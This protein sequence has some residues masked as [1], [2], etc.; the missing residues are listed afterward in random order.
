MIVLW[1]RMSGL[2]F[3][4]LCMA[5]VATST[6]ANAAENFLPEHSK[7]TATETR[8]P[9]RDGK[10]LAADV[11]L[12][13]SAKDPVATVLIQTPYDKNQS[14]G[15]FKVA[16]GQRGF[17][18]YTIK[19]CAIVITDWRGRAGSTDALIPESIPGGDEDGFDTIEWIISQPWCNGKIGSWGP[20]ALARVQFMTARAH[21]PNHVCA[22]PFVMPLNLDYD[23]YFPGGVLWEEFIRVLAS[24]GFDRRAWLLERPI[25]NELWREFER[26][27]FV[28]PSD[29]QIPM[30]VQGG[31]YDTY[32]DGVIRA[33]QDIKTGGGE[34][35][36]AHSRLLM[37]PWTH[38]SESA[39]QGELTFESAAYHGAEQAVEFLEHWLLGE[40]N[41]EGDKPPVTYYQMGANEWRTSQSWPPAGS[42]DVAYYLTPEK[43]LAAGD[44]PKSQSAFTFKADPANP[45]PRVG[46][47]LADASQGRGPA[48]QSK[49]VET[50]D[51]VVVFS[52]PVLDTDLAIAG[53]PRVVI[54]VSTDG[55]D[56]DFTAILTDVHP[57]GRSFVISEGIQ[58]LRFRE[59]TNKEVLAEPGK[60]YE[61]EIVLQSTA[62]TF[63][64]GH[65]VR[66]ILASSS[67]P[68]WALNPNDGKA[69]YDGHAGRI[70]TNTIHVGADMSRIV[71][72]CVNK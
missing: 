68:G 9:M 56:T 27:A 28:K 58:R 36:R 54:H 62:I 39:K 63:K 2:L 45:V 14:R 50:R 22:V 29:I 41:G 20:S 23:I 21:H 6:R 37:G 64:K 69:M 10:H 53:Q 57:D 51:D 42:R 34:K 43:S 71:L 16:E 3:L 47:R 52:T 7:F 40:D 60:V 5:V 26:T 35:T 30:F 13:K 66:L 11:Y 38:S 72:P 44:A 17:P 31:W 24:I 49:K 1:N 32:T 55:P 46:G 65:R 8:I 12:P 33:Y 18:L 15:G 67:H 25:N 70:A 48:D 59:G 61:I 4:A 19:D